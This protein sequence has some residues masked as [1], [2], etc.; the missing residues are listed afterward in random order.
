MLYKLYCNVNPL[1]AT[2]PILHASLLYFFIILLNAFR[3][4]FIPLS[5]SFIRVDYRS[6]GE[7]TRDQLVE[8]LPVNG[9]FPPLL[10]PTFDSTPPTR[11]IVYHVGTHSPD[12]RSYPVRIPALSDVVSLILT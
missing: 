5:H 12:S 8:A 9:N 7:I 1:Q 3:L 4:S 2:H 10:N 6:R 11:G